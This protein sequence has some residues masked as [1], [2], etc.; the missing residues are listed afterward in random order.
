VLLGTGIAPLRRWPAVALVALAVPV[1]EGLQ[2]LTGREASWSDVAYGY[3]GWLVGGLLMGGRRSGAGIAAA[4]LAL[5]T[6]YPVAVTFDHL[7][8]RLAFPEL[9][10]ADGW[11]AR[12]R[13]TVTGCTMEPV[14]EGWR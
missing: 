10:G 12:S 8:M 7:R 11:L 4:V 3:A 2:S 13:W 1:V 6:V 9:A 14:A 5:T